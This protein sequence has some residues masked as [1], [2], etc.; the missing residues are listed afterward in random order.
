MSRIDKKEGSFG[1]D[2]NR[3]VQ[4]I[5][6]VEDRS[7]GEAKRQE[8][9][10][11]AEIGEERRLVVIGYDDKGRAKKKYVTKEEAADMSSDIAAQ[12]ERADSPKGAS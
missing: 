1:L 10:P 2:P 7:Q 6:R 9:R 3:R 8:E 12:W 5:S 4:P 11:E